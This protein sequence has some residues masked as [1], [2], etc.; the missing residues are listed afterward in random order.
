MHG[1]RITGGLFMVIA[2]ISLFHSPRFSSYQ[3][4]SPTPT[5]SFRRTV[6]SEPSHQP[7]GTP[8]LVV[9][10]TLTDTPVQAV[11]AA[12]QD[13]GLTDYQVFEAA[14]IQGLRIISAQADLMQILAQPPF[15]AL[16]VE[17]S[18]MEQNTLT[19]QVSADR[20]QQIRELP[21]VIFRP[22]G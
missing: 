8:I 13:Q 22:G 16:L 9:T 1:G 17:Q 14:T 12:A 2:V 21:G 6:P 19:I 20:V 15:N 3:P 4:Q 5:Q 7:L 18:I 10:I 11:T